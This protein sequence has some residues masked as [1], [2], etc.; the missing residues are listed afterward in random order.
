MKD[1]RPF[2]PGAQPLTMRLLCACLTAASGTPTAMAEPPA[3]PAP[4]PPAL[5]HVVGL[6]TDL[7]PVIG[8]GFLTVGTPQII[9]TAKSVTSDCIAVLVG[10]NDQF[11][12]VDKW[13]E[14]THT[15]TTSITAPP[16]WEERKEKLLNRELEA[17]TEITAHPLPLTGT[18]RTYTGKIS[19]AGTANFEEVLP[20]ESPG[21]PVT[22][23]SGRIVGMCGNQIWGTESNIIPASKMKEHNNWSP[24]E[25]KLTE[26]GKGALEDCLV[27]KNGLEFIRDRAE[28]LE[29]AFAPI[30]AA[31]EHIP[32]WLTASEATREKMIGAYES[33][34]T[35]QIA[36]PWANVTN[37]APESGPT[38]RETLTRFQQAS[39]ILEEAAKKYETEMWAALQKTYAAREAATRMGV[40][41]AITKPFQ[42][43][44][45]AG[46]ELAR[47]CLAFQQ[48][49]NEK[50]VQAAQNKN[51]KYGRLKIEAA[52]ALEGQEKI[53]PERLLQRDGE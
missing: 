23:K 14:N 40:V 34:E 7:R 9:L 3:P 18:P 49:Q 36:V 25:T 47:E 37:P 11:E 46:D 27:G 20:A 24:E 33:L 4:A 38:T 51:A 50:G 17:E 30:I 41:E 43:L 52:T 35:A 5:V 32:P 48:S 39:K 1:Q 8:T 19:A 12:N 42:A 2:K 45:K 29:K 31:R 21:S 26:K 28:R 22:D 13:W 10:Q 16:K 44:G 15:D 53:D 6:K